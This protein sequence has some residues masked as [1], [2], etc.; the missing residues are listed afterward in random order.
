MKKAVKIIVIVIAALLFAGL[1]YLFCTAYPLYEEVANR[2]TNERTSDENLIKW[3]TEDKSFDIEEFRAS[4]HIEEISITSSDDGH[5]IPAS[6]IYALESADK[7]GN[8]VIMVHGLLGNR[9]SNYPMSQMFLNLGYNVITYDQ[10]SSG[11]NTAS[12]TTFGYLESRDTE[13][14]VSYAAENMTDGAV[15]GLWGQSMGAATAENA[16]NADVVVKNVDFVVLDSA[17]GNM[18]DIIRHPSEWLTVLAA[19]VIN[20]VNLGFFYADQ[21]VYPQIENTQIPVLSAS[22]TADTSIPFEIQESVYNSI[23]SDKKE[24]Y[25]V[26]DCDHSDIY[27]T[28]PDEYQAKIAEFIEKFVA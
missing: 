18:E 15:L 6:Y 10:R 3:L 25:T 13:D 28:H 19:S 21:R 14:C 12:H 7:S 8:T 23:K 1:V 22:S 27:F 16:M 5:I 24:F 20:R 11:G 2:S 17:M 26:D 4:Y 9:L